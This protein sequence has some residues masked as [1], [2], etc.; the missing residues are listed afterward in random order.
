M[1]SSISPNI[2]TSE[3]QPDLFSR[4]ATLYSERQALPLQYF[5]EY[6]DYRVAA[7]WNKV[8]DKSI[9]ITDAT[10]NPIGLA[11][12]PVETV[13][14]KYQSI[15]L[16]EDYIPAP[17]ANSQVAE[18]FLY[19]YIDK[20]ALSERCGKAMLTHVDKLENLA[21]NSNALVQ[22]GYVDT[23]TIDLVVDLSLNTQDI[24]NQL[25]NNHKRSIKKAETSPNLSLRWISSG[26]PNIGHHNSYKSLHHLCAG[27]VTRPHES[28]TQ[29]YNMLLKGQALLLTL[30]YNDK[31]VGSLYI[32][33]GTVDSV[34]ASGADDPDFN[35]F[36]LYH[37]MIWEAIKKL[38]LMNIKRFYLGWPSGRHLVQG[39]GDYYTPKQLSIAHF[40]RGFNGIERNIFRGVRY[41]DRASLRND[42]HR[43][44]KAMR[45]LSCN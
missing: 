43:F 33:H 18:Q 31:I 34:Y 27:R 36:P 38:K 6:F 3:F 11:Y 2:I 41:Y 14:N 40:K 28:F 15:S 24:F 23:S 32:F 10:G 13:E 22:Y 21:S 39:F 9:V 8:K 44:A 16:N 4:A 37:I 45:N 20:I 29:Q 26:E 35:D 30:A 17:L 5:K 7:T 25:R 1:P 42:I 12:C 19:R